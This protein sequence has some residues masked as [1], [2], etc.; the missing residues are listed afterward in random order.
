MESQCLA[1]DCPGAMTTTKTTTTSTE[2][3]GEE[4]GYEPELGPPMVASVES[5]TSSGYSLCISSPRRAFTGGMP[6]LVTA[7][8][9]I[10]G[11]SLC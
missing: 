6:F 5:T 4:E 11:S 8:L 3:E 10:Y 7:V 9:L 2:E 1:Q